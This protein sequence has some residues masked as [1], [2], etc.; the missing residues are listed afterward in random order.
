[1]FSFRQ[2]ERMSGPRQT[3]F[4]ILLITILILLLLGVSSVTAADY[5]IVKALDCDNCGQIGGLI[6]NDHDWNGQRGPGEHG[7]AAAMVR[8]WMLK[9]GKYQ[10]HRASYTGPGG[11]YSFDELV[12]GSYRIEVVEPHSVTLQHLTQTKLMSPTPVIDVQEG[13]QFDFDFSYARVGPTV[14]PNLMPGP[15]D[16]P[17]FRHGQ[18]MP[19][20]PMLYDHRGTY[21]ESQ[22][23]AVFLKVY[24]ETP[25]SNNNGGKP[26]P[27]SPG[28]KFTNYD[29][30]GVEHRH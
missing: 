25:A 16:L 7:I 11:T 24:Q 10:I 1:M 15:I 12:V 21:P 22:P 18:R 3:H 19:F 14:H 28:Q 8:L 26:N 27:A 20:Y 29:I 5:Q 6:W 4:A 9:D 2:T 13:Q 30:V 17:N 23:A